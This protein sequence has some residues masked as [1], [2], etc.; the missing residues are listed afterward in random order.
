ME[1]T[2]LSCRSFKDIQAQLR[3][4]ALAQD[5]GDFVR[6]LALPKCVEHWSLTTLREKLI[7]IGAKVAPHS[8]YVF[9]QLAF[10]QRQ[11]VATLESS[12]FPLIALAPHAASTSVARRTSA[13]PIKA[14]PLQGAPQ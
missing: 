14:P 8:R 12:T 2:R 1:W 11:P 4:L 5:F 7:K 13:P 3:L 6:R 9:F 10:A